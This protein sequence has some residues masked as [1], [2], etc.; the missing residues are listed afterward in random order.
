MHIEEASLVL[1]TALLLVA[2]YV[3]ALCVSIADRFTYTNDGQ[4]SK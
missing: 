2:P 4:V 1:F 3:F